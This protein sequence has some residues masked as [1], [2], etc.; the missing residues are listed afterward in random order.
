MRSN[1]VPKYK[2]SFIKNCNKT[3]KTFSEKNKQQREPLEYF[4]LITNF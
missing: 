2:I 1:H 4:L 3:A